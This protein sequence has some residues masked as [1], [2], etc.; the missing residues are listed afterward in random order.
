MTGIVVQVG[1][2][3][4]LTPVAEFTPVLLAGTVV[5]RATLHNHEDL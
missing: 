1:R 3:G 4:V 5:R 2:T